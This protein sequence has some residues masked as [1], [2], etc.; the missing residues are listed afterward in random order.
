MRDLLTSP[1]AFPKESDGKELQPARALGDRFPDPPSLPPAGIGA[2]PRRQES[3]KGGVFRLGAF[4]GGSSNETELRRQ[5]REYEQRL[6]DMR[7]IA[8]KQAVDISQLRSVAETHLTAAAAKGQ[9]QL[10]ELAAA[11]KQEGTAREE[12]RWKEMMQAASAQQEQ[13][14]ANGQ[15][16]LH[17]LAAA[18]QTQQQKH[19]EAQATEWRKVLH[20]TSESH[21]RVVDQLQENI[22]GL[23]AE[24]S[25]LEAEQ[26]RLHEK[27][28]AASPPGGGG[29]AKRSAGE[30]AEAEA[31]ERELSSQL[32]EA[33]G[34]AEALRLELADA[35]RSAEE[36]KAGEEARIEA[37]RLQMGEAMEAMGERLIEM[38]RLRRQACNALQEA[39]GSIRVLA[40]ARP[41]SRGELSGGEASALAFPSH[42]ALALSEAEGA[43]PSDFSFDACLGETASQAALYDEA[44]PAVCSVL[45]GQYVCVMAYG[46]TGAGKTFTMQGGGGTPGL[47]QLAAAELIEEAQQ[48]RAARAAQGQ[49]LSVRFEASMLEVYNEKVLDLLTRSGGGDNLE[50]R[51]AAD[52]TVSV[53]GLTRRDVDSA[54]AIGRLLAEGQE[55]RHTHATLMNAGSS[56]SHLILTLHAHLRSEPDG[57]EWRGKLHLVDL[58]GS[59]RVGKSGVT[60]EQLREAQ[61]IN[62]SLSALEQVCNRH[63]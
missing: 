32:D 63:V 52:G 19:S 37:V 50:V 43:A 60:G 51:A 2:S 30:R 55:R 20:E 11:H 3:D 18:L 46:Q 61:A 57:V 4:F 44:S 21:A 33:R 17:E 29:G 26:T 13:A 16:Q 53:P 34:E 45:Q 49:T 54:E 12:E 42:S 27:L 23:L 9:E 36:V 47:V 1:E 31:R 25:K 22:R 35:T 48:L 58:A 38:C 8:S 62:K 14:L 56:R 28:T 40:R 41:L 6:A 59:E 5:I 10:A 15:A 7:D 24:K 39:R